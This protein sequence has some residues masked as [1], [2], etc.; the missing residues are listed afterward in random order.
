MACIL[1]KKGNSLLEIAQALEVEPDT[2]LN[3]IAIKTQL[4]KNTVKMVFNSIKLGLSIHEMPPSIPVEA[5][6][7][8]VPKTLQTVLTSNYRAEIRE[9]SKEFTVAQIATYLGITNR[10]IE[11][12]LASEDSESVAQSQSPTEGIDVQIRGPILGGEESKTPVPRQPKTEERF[13]PP[14]LS[15]VYINSSCMQSKLPQEM[16]QL[17]VNS[18]QLS[19]VKFGRYG[20]LLMNEITLNSASKLSPFVF[21]DDLKDGVQVQD[22]PQKTLENGA[23]YRG[24]WSMSG[25]YRH[26]KGVQEWEDGSRYEGYW[27]NDRAFGKGRLIHADGDVYEGMWKDDKK[28]GKGVY[29]HVNG[30]RY[31]GSWEDDKLNGNGVAIWPDGN[32]YE[33][34]YAD[35]KKQGKGTFC[36]ANKSTYKG[37]FKDNNLHGQGSYVW[38]DGKQYTGDWKFNKMDGEGTFKWTDGRTYKGAYKDNKKDGFGSFTW[39]DGRRYD[40]FWVNGK[41]HG[42][43]CFITPEGVKREGVWKEGKRTK[44]INFDT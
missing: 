24:E 34:G 9:R 39:P 29:I 33:G 36:L 30:A 1:S 42:K 41:Q 28:H 32:R 27:A 26:G 40:G 3:L 23:I 4:D 22:F 19:A 2:V 21:D 38:D 44:W 31:E 10:E 20:P 14:S 6:K 43:G 15:P 25:Q 11:D 37:D 17:A 16:T 5:L 13:E 8:F 18:N 35:G 12:V 7:I